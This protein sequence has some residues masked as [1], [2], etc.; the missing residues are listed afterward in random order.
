MHEGWVE[1]LTTSGVCDNLYVN[2]KTVL[3]DVLYV[4]SCGNA[5]KTEILRAEYEHKNVYR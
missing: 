4:R 1:A 2:V 5:V 3:A